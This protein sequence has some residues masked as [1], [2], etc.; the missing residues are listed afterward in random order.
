[1]L[2]RLLLVHLPSASLALPL[3]YPAPHL[4]LTPLSYP[5]ASPAPHRLCLAASASPPLPHCL[6]LTRSSPTTTPVGACAPVRSNGVVRV[7]GRRVATSAANFTK[8]DVVGVVLDADQG[9]IV[10]FRNG[11]CPMRAPHQV[12]VSRC[13]SVGPVQ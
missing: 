13:S 12:A 7:G 1:M 10:F 4:P 6:C 8:G 3:S 11:A 2:M 9:E 5:C